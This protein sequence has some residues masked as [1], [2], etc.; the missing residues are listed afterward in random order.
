M[1]EK[2]GGRKNNNKAR[3]EE[4]KQALYLLFEQIF[5]KD[6]MESIIEDAKDARDAE[7]GSYT[8]KLIGGVEERLEELDKHIEANLK[9]WRKNRIS[10]VSLT[11][12]RMAVYEMLYVDEIPVSVSINE[13]VELAK[14]FATPADGS[15]VNGV[16]GSIA[17]TV[18][19]SGE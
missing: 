11:I 12:M 10:K 6:S 5:Q 13:A 8:R 19:K 18:E 2:S 14:E 15:F 7:I 3:H 16:L 1:S 4:R 9:G 17:K